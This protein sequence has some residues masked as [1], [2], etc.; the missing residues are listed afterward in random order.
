MAIVRVKVLPGLLLSLPNHQFFPGSG[1]RFGGTLARCRIAGLQ[2]NRINLIILVG[3][4]DVSW[5][6]TGLETAPG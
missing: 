5:K 4:A 3:S 6:H 2:V 1:F